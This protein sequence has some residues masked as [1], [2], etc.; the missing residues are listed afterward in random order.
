[1]ATIP[2]TPPAQPTLPGSKRRVTIPTYGESS[3]S[4]QGGFA[5]PY[6]AGETTA[7]LV[8]QITETLNTIADKDAEQNAK[9]KGYQEQQ[10]QIEAG[11][12]EYL[13]S[14]NAFSISGR[15]YQQGASVAMINNKKGE[16]DKKLSELAIKRQF[17]SEAFLKEATEL[18]TT[19]FKNIPANLQAALDEDFEKSKNNFNTQINI[20]TLQQTFE[21]NKKDVKEG[22]YRDTAKIFNSISAG[23]LTSADMPD[24]FA[25]IARNLNSLKTDYNAGPTELRETV[26]EIR[27]N[28]A[29]HYLR[30]E[31]D[32]RA[33]QPDGI[34]KLKNE[35]R[36]GQ[37]TFGELGEEFG[38][39]IPGGKELT[40]NEQAAYLTIIEKYEKEYAKENAGQ[41]F[42]FK[43][44]TEGKINDLADGFGG[45]QAS[46]NE[47]GRLVV[48][49]NPALMAY[50]VSKATLLGVPKEDQLE[51][52]LNLKAAHMAGSIVLKAALEDEA[53]MSDAKNTIKAWKD[54]L[55]SISDPT[56]KALYRKAITYAESRVDD[57]IKKR[58][59]DKSKGESF[60]TY[61]QYRAVFGNT[62]YIDTN[63]APGLRKLKTEYEQWN[64]SPLNVSELPTDMGQADV[65]IVKDS[66]NRS[67][68]DGVSALT[69]LIQN[70]DEF[71]IPLLIAGIKS[72]PKAEKN[73][74]WALA[75]AAS[76]IKQGKIADAEQILTAF[77]DNTTLT[78]NLPNIMGQERYNDSIKTYE[79]KFRKEFGQMLIGKA[80]YSKGIYNAGLLLFKKNLEADPNKNA[81][82][83]AAATINFL[84]RTNTVTELSNGNKIIYDNSESSN[85]YGVDRSGIIKRELDIAFEKPW[86]SNL[87]MTDGQTWDRL[88][89]NADKYTYGYD[90]GGNFIL[91]DKSGDVVAHPLQKYPSDGDTLLASDFIIRVNGSYK[92]KAVFTDVEKTWGTKVKLADKLPKLYEEIAPKKDYN[93]SDEV[94]DFTGKEEQKLLTYA[95]ALQKTFS[96]ENAKLP[97]NEK[98]EDWAVKMV[99]GQD[100]VK[101]TVM[102]AISQ[103]AAQGDLTDADL[104][105][106]VQNVP[107]ANKVN[108]N[109]AGTRQY[110]VRQFKQNFATV[111]TRT[112]STDG[113]TRLSPIQAIL[114]TAD[115]YQDVLKDFVGSLEPTNVQETG[116]LNP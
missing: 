36:T 107:I 39:F 75:N 60:N 101:Q 9:I 12:P 113:A 73:P 72:D 15:A 40:V 90:W 104:L 2:E 32:N 29:G 81:S 87:V 63:T 33:L 97:P 23:G 96:Q 25:S 99:I 84:T 41:K 46:Y 67:I 115:S 1:M 37:Y 5:Q 17:N 14:G 18:K 42:I 103:K 94:G 108:L 50:D 44:E 71:A 28:I 91:R 100:T 98:Y 111:S 65:I 35:I 88:D 76:L 78:E 106:M 57:I 62:E 74:D 30:H 24:Y 89:S 54:N 58:L 85:K 49:D 11:N 38:Q 7:R 112:S 19:I 56:S 77:K 70:K 45:F 69:Q 20:Q 6:I 82:D 27:S 66:L 34:N 79:D 64:N 10:A 48:K 93:F 52:Q 13:G 80:S 21:N 26:T 109:N 3:A 116:V 22:I 16:F 55:N 86:L 102:Q 68:S 114:A 110:V 53:V 8:G 43:T 31:F 105:W 4:V 47:Q 61:L 83:A 92:P 95:Q 59:E 51:D